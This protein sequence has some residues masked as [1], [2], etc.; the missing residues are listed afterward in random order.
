MPGCLFRG[1]EILHLE[2]RGMENAFMTS[3]K[4]R[5]TLSQPVAKEM[6][7][8]ALLEADGWGPSCDLKSSVGKGS[9]TFRPHG[10]GDGAMSIEFDSIVKFKGI[11]SNND[12]GGNK[13]KHSVEF[14]L[15][16]SSKDALANLSQYWMDNQRIFHHLQVKFHE[17]LDGPPASGKPEGK[18]SAGL[19]D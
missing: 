18:A 2:L 17:L 11:E 7:W 12:A 5:A 1:V 15:K 4:M 13:A 19:E 10:K 14:V 6:G 3:M 16:T 9:G 8:E